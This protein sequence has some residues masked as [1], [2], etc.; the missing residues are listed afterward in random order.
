M[1]Y[2]DELIICSMYYPRLTPPLRA[3]TF[4]LYVAPSLMIV[5]TSCGV[6]GYVMVAGW[7]ENR[8][9]TVKMGQCSALGE[10]QRL[11]RCAGTRV[12]T[13]PGKDGSNIC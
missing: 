5:D 7:N 9:L 10:R 6:C 3:A 1:L 12:I 4:R 8:R 11:T 13:I 2:G